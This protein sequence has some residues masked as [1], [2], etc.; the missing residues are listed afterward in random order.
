MEAKSDFESRFIA[1]LKTLDKQKA[2]AA[3][4]TIT[5]EDDDTLVGI[6]TIEGY[7]GSEKTS[8]YAPSIN[9]FQ[10]PDAHPYV[11]DLV[12][13]KKYGPDWLFWEPETL[14]WQIPQDF[15]TD[16]ISA[17]NMG[18]IQ[19]IKVLHFNDTYWQRWEVFTHCTQ[20]FNNNYVDFDVLQVPSTGQVMVSVDIAARVREDVVWS[21]EVKLYMAT[22]CRYDGIFCP[23]DPITFLEVP[24]EHGLVDCSQIRELWPKVRASDKAPTDDTIVAEQLR[25]NLDVHRFLVASRQRLEKQL[26]LVL[27]A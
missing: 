26:P 10:H 23:P 19:A 7:T 14:E 5:E 20:P 8:Q 25:R 6:E 15:K 18:K 4:Q 22:A 16:A 1:A 3:R 24:V 13:L 11:L 12:L 17:L 2:E 21:E 27:N 9:L